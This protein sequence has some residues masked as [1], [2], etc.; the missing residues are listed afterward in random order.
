MQQHS[1]IQICYN[2]WW[3]WWK[4]KYVT[5]SDDDD[6]DDESVVVIEVEE[7][8][9][10]H[11]RSRQEGKHFHHKHRPYEQA[12]TAAAENKEMQQQHQQ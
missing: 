10:Q 1:V 7:D 3:R 8:K 4:C 9:Q 5:I 11:N 6:D 12:Y 2:I